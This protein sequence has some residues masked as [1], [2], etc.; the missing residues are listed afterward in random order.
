MHYAPTR[1]IRRVA[2]KGTWQVCGV[3]LVGAAGRGRWNE[4]K[5]TGTNNG[6]GYF[7]GSPGAT[8]AENT[9]IGNPDRGWRVGSR[10]SGTRLFVEHSGELWDARRWRETQ[11]KARR[12]SGN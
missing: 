3:G 11:G 6:A 8:Q 2:Q 9:W 1:T 10:T 7:D 5:R 4:T 12:A